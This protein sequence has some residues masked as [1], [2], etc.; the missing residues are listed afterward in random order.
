MVCRSC[1]ACFVSNTGKSLFHFHQTYALISLVDASLFHGAFRDAPSWNYK[2][3]RYHSIRKFQCTGSRNFRF[4][5]FHKEQAD[6]ARTFHFSPCSTFRNEEHVSD[7]GHTLSR[8]AVTPGT[9]RGN[10]LQ[11]LVQSSTRT[12]K[13]EFMRTIF[14][15]ASW[16]DATIFPSIITP[17]PASIFWKLTEIDVSSP[18]RS[19]WSLTSDSMQVVNRA[20]ANICFYSLP[21]CQQSAGKIISSY[22]VFI[23]TVVSK[24]RLLARKP[25]EENKSPF[26]LS[27]LYTICWLGRTTL[28]L[29]LLLLIVKI[30]NRIAIE[31][32]QW[33]R[34]THTSKV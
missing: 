33:R 31:D 8:H 29:S 19:F 5:P 7:G 4:I 3:P 13:F 28:I 1:A 10:S 24:L 25:L 22:R 26:L 9:W 23:F 15:Y 32:S 16:R 6:A 34:F 20:R 30:P 18:S 21:D 12:F 27:D 2:W 14:I 17:H 11:G